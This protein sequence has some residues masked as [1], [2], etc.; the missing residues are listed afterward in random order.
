MT[1]DKRMR[2]LIYKRTHEGDPNPETGIF[3]NNDCMKQVRG[4]SFDAV[5]GVGGIGPEPQKKG[6]ARKLTWIGVGPHKSIGQ[7]CPLVTFDHFLYLGKQ[8][9]LLCELA[10]NLA[11]HIYDGKVR[12]IM[13]ALSNEE[14]LEVKNIL[15]LAMH[16]PSSKQLTEASQQTFRKTTCKR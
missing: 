11:K 13:D 5:I 12:I 15:S 9:T 6:I 14:H 1:S 16:E 2:T 3:G 7:R 4:W 10:P 8:G